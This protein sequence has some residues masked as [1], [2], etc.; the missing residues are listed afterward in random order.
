MTIRTLLLFT[1][2]CRFSFGVDVAGSLTGL[3]AKTAETLIHQRSAVKQQSLEAIVPQLIVGGEW[4][5]TLRF[6]NR[7]STAITGANMFFVDNLGNP[8]TV[9]FQT[10]TT[11]TLGQLIKGDPIVTSAATLTLNPGIGIEGTF[12]GTATAQFGH[13]LIDTCANRGCST[14][15][16][17]G[18]VI[19]RNRNS[20]R[21]DFESV[22]PLE[23]P[24]SLQYMPFDH[25][26][27]FT[28]TF[29]LVSPLSASTVTLDFRNLAGQSLRTVSLS[30]L[31]GE[32][33]ILSLHA[34][35]PETLGSMGTLVINSGNAFVVPTALRINPSNSFTPIRAYI[36]GN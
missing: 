21:P 1:L 10:V 13:V 33:K 7:S 31:N 27:G 12:F 2:F 14:A 8:M 24:A 25:R 22:F 4:N 29:Y 35:A 5:S 16:I 9:T 20:T 3:D 26:D 30:M 15:G 32:S 36:P 18:E 17:Y 23:Q 28:T 34:L 19:L 11:N 6:F